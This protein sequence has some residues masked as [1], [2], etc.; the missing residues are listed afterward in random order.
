MLK[1]PIAA[2]LILTTTQIIKMKIKKI[3]IKKISRKIKMM[4][5]PNNN[6][7]KRSIMTA[8]KISRRLMIQPSYTL[9]GLILRRK[10]KRKIK[11]AWS[12]MMIRMKKEMSFMF[13]IHFIKQKTHLNKMKWNRSSMMKMLTVTRIKKINSNLQFQFCT[14]LNHLKERIK[15]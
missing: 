3:L 1:L 6:Q 5:N 9:S 4:D 8:N 7:I 13:K 10:V 11:L 2:V 14:G 15:K 12:L